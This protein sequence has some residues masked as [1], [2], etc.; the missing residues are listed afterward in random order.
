MKIV[1]HCDDITWSAFW[2]VEA[3]GVANTKTVPDGGQHARQHHQQVVVPGQ[4]VA[5]SRSSGAAKYE[6]ETFVG[7]HSWSQWPCE[8]PAGAMRFRCY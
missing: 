4:R 3:N 8:S 5:V 1:T 2:S 6:A 7:A